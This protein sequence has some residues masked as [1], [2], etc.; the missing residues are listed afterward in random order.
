MQLA[1]LEQTLSPL[2][3]SEEALRAI[4][5][6]CAPL[7]TAERLKIWNSDNALIRRPIMPEE[8]VEQGF[9][10]LE[11]RFIMLQGDIVR[12]DSAYHLGNRITGFPK[13][14]IL[15]SS[16][17]LVPDRSSSSLLLRIA[18]IKRSD[19]DA[20]QKLGVLAKF[21]RRDCMYMPLLQDDPEDIVGSE[22][23]FDEICQIR[24]ADLL[25]AN[26]A[27]SLTLVG[28]RIFASFS[29]T[30]IARANPREIEIRKAF[31]PS[32]NRDAAS[33]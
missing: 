9:C 22:V 3:H 26:R 20:K 12:T 7:N 33:A 16:C 19:P 25:L 24:T 30:V 8:V 13:Y 21:G 31:E 2:S 29:R 28:W 1:D 11:D 27:A 32:P 10:G 5:D 6:F 15:N 4:S 18:D 14:A 23:Q 17:D